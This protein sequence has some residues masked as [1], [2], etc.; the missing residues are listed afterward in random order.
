MDAGSDHNGSSGGGASRQ[1]AEHQ[2]IVLWF[3]ND[4]RLHDNAI[5]HE[6]VQRAAAQPHAQVGAACCCMCNASPV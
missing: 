1:Q 6:A 4:L 2:T 3:R 5:V